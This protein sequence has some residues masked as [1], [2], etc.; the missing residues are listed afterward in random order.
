[1]ENIEKLYKELGTETVQSLYEYSCLKC[2]GFND[3]LASKLIPLLH[4]LWLEDNYCRCISQLS[5]NLYDVYENNDNK[6]DF[7]ELVSNELLD[8]EE[9]EIGF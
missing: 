3:G 8:L 2:S 1:M 7:L 4:D 6:E 9:F 5:D